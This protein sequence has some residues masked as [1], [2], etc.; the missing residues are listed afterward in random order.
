MWTHFRHLHF[1]NFPIIWRTFQSNEFWPLKSLFENLGIHQ[2]SNSQS[3]SSLNS[4]GVHSLTLSYTPRSMKCCSWASFLAHTFTSL[5]LGHEFKNGV[6]TITLSCLGSDNALQMCGEVYGMV[7]STTFIIVKD[8]CVGMRKHL[9]PLVIKRL[10]SSNIRRLT[11]EFEK[12]Q[13]IYIFWGSR[14]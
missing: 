5:C 12:L 9:K 13:R 3:G 7:K 14:W 6:V 1:K 11:H 8:L 10:T 2:D 4:V